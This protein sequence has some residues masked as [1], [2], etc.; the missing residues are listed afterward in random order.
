MSKRYFFMSKSMTKI[1]NLSKALVKPVTKEELEA[2]KL[3]PKN[4]TEAKQQLAIKLRLQKMGMFDD[5]S[6]NNQIKKAKH[7]LSVSHS[8]RFEQG[9]VDSV[10]TEK[11]SESN[12]R[13][14]GKTAD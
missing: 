2:I 11:I 14:R 6:V 12:K 9:I 13:W 3:P 8:L 1:N 4:R 10:D 7:S 5:H